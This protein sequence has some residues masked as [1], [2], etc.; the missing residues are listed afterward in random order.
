[1]GGEVERRCD[2]RRHMQHNFIVSA[3][4]GGGRAEA[5]IFE[6]L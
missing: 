5:S 1:M 2:W 6:A 4:R 3:R